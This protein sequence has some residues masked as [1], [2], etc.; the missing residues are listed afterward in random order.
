MMP[1][2]PL[3]SALL[4]TISSTSLGADD[5]DADVLP[6]PPLEATESQPIQIEPQ[7]ENTNNGQPAASAP[8]VLQMETPFPQIPLA[9]PKHHA[10]ASI[11]IEWPPLQQA[12]IDA[13]HEQSN[14]QA[15]PIGLHRPIP[16][17]YRGN[18]IED[19]DF[20]ISGDRQRAL[21]QLTALDAASIRAQFRASLPLDSSLTFLGTYNEHAGLPPTVWTQ[22]YLASR[23]ADTTAIWSPSGEAG[24]L[25]IVVDTPADIDLQGTFLVLEAISQRWISLSDS[26]DD[27]TLRPLHESSSRLKCPYHYQ[28]AACH[29][30]RYPTSTSESQGGDLRGVVV[31]YHFES[32]PSR[33]SYV[34]S[35]ALI[36]QK[37]QSRQRKLLI[38]A[39]HCVSTRQE[40]DSIET[41]HYYV[42]SSC[43]A[44][45]LHSRRFTTSDGAVYLDGLHSADQTLVEL[46]GQFFGP[47]WFSGWTTGWNPSPLG[48]PVYGLHHPAGH[49]MAFSLGR[50]TTRR[51]IYVTDYGRVLDAIPVNNHV[52]ATE[53]GSS[54]SGLF[55]NNSS[56]DSRLVGV[57]SAG[58]GCDDPSFYGSFR[59]FYPVARRFVDPGSTEAALKLIGRA[60][61]FPRDL[62]VT[63]QGF[64]YAINSSDRRATATIRA[65]SG[66][67]PYRFSLACRFTIP[68]RAVRAFN[69]QD[70]ETGNSAKG[71]TGTGR[72]AGDWI[73]EFYSDIRTVR[74]Y[75]YA[76]ALD[77]TGFVNSLS[78]TAKRIQSETG[79]WYFLPIL[80]P[81]SN[82]LARSEVRITN[83][84]PRSASNVRLIGYDSDGVQFPR[85][86]STYLARTLSVNQTSVFTSQDL[87]YGNS[88]RLRGSRFGD[89]AGKWYLWI[90]S[91]NAPLEVTALMRSR[92]LTSNLSQ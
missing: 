92:G 44:S 78:G 17:G 29:T 61:F 75:T 38:T 69:S 49:R 43:R 85:F 60:P 51:S 34:C 84:G 45:S 6:L 46:R 82:L 20:T 5:G 7:G 11:T 26:T 58:L 62:L 56:R 66:T 81:A 13:A 72:G 2:I 74:F 55:F 39:H 22:S 59:D 28:D 67:W 4:I 10:P 18:L 64:I 40:A 19:L 88:A 12:E 9:A 77:D 80:N 42:N 37:G 16:P 89:G 24:E 33:L 53:G 32:G 52:G 70:L 36:A 86:G 35:G 3:L 90:Y 23:Q 48:T 1:V 76:R 79:H 87:E 50:A 65:S 57:L 30:S 73:L 15:L 41:I 71:C 63:Q 25:G 27:S 31:H 8:G 91:P 47:V 21:I 14:S 54:G 83:L 68:P